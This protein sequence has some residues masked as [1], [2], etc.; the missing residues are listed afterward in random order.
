ML[1]LENIYVQLCSNHKMIY[2]IIYVSS[3]P[4]DRKDSKTSGVGCREI[5]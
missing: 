2:E 3:L 1:L 4:V 5:I